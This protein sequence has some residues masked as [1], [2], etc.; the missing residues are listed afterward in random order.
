[1][2]EVRL[3]RLQEAIH[4]AISEQL[5]GSVADPRLQSV[6][7]SRVQMSQDGAN[8]KV[9]ILVREDQSDR[10]ALVALRHARGF[11][12]HAVA[13]RLGLRLAPALHFALDRQVSEMM[14]IRQFF[15]QESH[16]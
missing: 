11:L 13:Q 2:H 3:A 5:L 8:A 6:T 10:E 16:D 1:M 7:V 15:S 14:A 9:F 4:R 12:R